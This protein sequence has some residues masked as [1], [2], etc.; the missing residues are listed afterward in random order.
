MS[1]E[2]FKIYFSAI[3]YG[4]VALILFGFMSAIGF[5]AGSSL[6][7]TEWTSVSEAEAFEGRDMYLGV[8]GFLL[9]AFCKF[10]LT[11]MKEN[12]CE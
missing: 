1:G 7:L 10:T 3:G 11:S 4:S 5:S 12:E 2:V 9:F 6:W 8:Y